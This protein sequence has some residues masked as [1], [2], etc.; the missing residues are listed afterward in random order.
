MLSQLQLSADSLGIEKYKS[1]I[2]LRAKNNRGDI[3]C[4]ITTAKEMNQ[5]MERGE[6]RFFRG[7]LQLQH[8]NGG[9]NI[10]VK[11]EL[12]ATIPIQELKKLISNPTV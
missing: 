10:F 5:F 12:I 2:R 4:R 3:V 9:V 1:G 7:R 6:G 11:N 8:S